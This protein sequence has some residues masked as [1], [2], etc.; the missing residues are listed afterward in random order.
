MKRTAAFILSLGMLFSAISCEKTGTS[1][2][3]SEKTS[4]LKTELLISDKNYHIKELAMPG[5]SGDVL[6]AAP[7]GGGKYIVAFRSPE[8][9]V[10]GFYTTD[11]QFTEYS[12]CNTGIEFRENAEIYVRFACAADGTLYAAV[13]EITH[14][15]IPPFNYLNPEQNG[16]SFDWESYYANAE[17]FHTVYKLSA[18]G[19]VLLKTEITGMEDSEIRDFTV[20]GGKLYISCDTVYIA[21]EVSGNAEVYKFPHCDS[22]G[23]LGVT[24]EDVLI[25]DGFSGMDNCL[26][27][28]DKALSLDWSGVPVSHISAGGSGFDA[29]FTG[30]TGIYGLK[31]DTLTEL[32][33]NVKLGINENA[34]ADIFPAEKGYV[35][36]VFDQSAISNRLYLLTDILEDEATR[37][38][39]TLKL[40]V[41][42]QTEDF[43]NHVA[44]FNRS[45]KNITIEPVYYNEYDIYDKEKDEQVSTGIGQLS[46][47]LITGEGP[48]IAV[49]MNTPLDLKGKGAF[50]DMYGLMDDE[51]SRDM[52]MPNILEACE[53][54]GKLYS[55][56][57]CFSVRSMAVKEKFSKVQDQTFEDMMEVIDNAPDSI[58]IQN[59]GSKREVLIS[60]LSYSNYAL[61]C[62]DGKYSINAGHMEKLLEFCNRFPD[63]ETGEWYDIGKDE[64]LFSDFAAAKF[65]DFKEYYDMFAEPVTFAGYPSEN[66]MGNVAV[67]TCNVA[68][69][70]KCRDKEAAWEFIKSI[71]V[72]NN[73]N[74]TLGRNMEFPV[75]KDDFEQ[76]AEIAENNGN[77]TKD[78]L[79]KAIE[80]VKSARRATSGLP[81]D[82][83]R[84]IIEEAQPY[85]AGECTAADAASYIKNRT[86]IY[87]SENE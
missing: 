53:Y 60:N 81:N 17:Y 10:P 61:S 42:Y 84:I 13:T 3:N 2:G 26:M 12:S 39:V 29:V 1:S 80:V 19:K 59:G 32:S 36:R 30:K 63:S 55:L 70:E 79:D 20:C 41:L 78:E 8:S 74:I 14:G 34:A 38:P 68:I 16:E 76:L 18:E 56:P 47:D 46:M 87:I 49:F 9:V 35:I 82:L 50:T 44:A 27:V 6:S 25:C 21:D 33:L 73:S 7:L 11:E 45:G 5:E 77:F 71:Y 22:I 54:G 85:F 67:M 4:A 62:E 83:Y 40:G 86:D 69:M 64:V 66:A 37:E 48:D 28:G 65:G 15:D 58:A 24:A 23:S 43:A 57:T 52:F 75:I 31:D 72:G 51:L